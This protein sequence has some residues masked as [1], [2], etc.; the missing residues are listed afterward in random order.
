MSIWKLLPVLVLFVAHGSHLHQQQLMEVEHNSRHFSPQ[1]YQAPPTLQSHTHHPTPYGNVP[2]RYI[3]PELKSIIDKTAEYVAK[4]SEDFERT[5][6]QRHAGDPRFEFLNP[7]DSNYAYYQAMKQYSRSV[8]EQEGVQL[9]EED[10]RTNLQKL[11]S[12]GTVSFKL[13]SKEAQAAGMVTPCQQF[14]GEESEEVI[15]VKN[16]GEEIN[17]EQ[18]LPPPKKQRI[19]GGGEEMGSTVEVSF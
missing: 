14:G 6:L 1:Q 10:Y 13:Q 18:S 4:N 15:E 3:P 7:W 16:P 5:V 11:S 19:N 12:S 9:G 2:P 8:L 17:N